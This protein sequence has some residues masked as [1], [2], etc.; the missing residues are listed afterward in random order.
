MREVEAARKAKADA[1]LTASLEAALVRA[2]T[3]EARVRDLERAVAGAKSLAQ[4]I[5][6]GY[7]EGGWGDDL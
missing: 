6:D 5:L 7:A 2:G 4:R 1:E 3:A